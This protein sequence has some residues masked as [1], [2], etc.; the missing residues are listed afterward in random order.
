MSVQKVYRITL[1]KIMP[2]NT[3]VE[4]RQHF[5]FDANMSEV[6]SVFELFRNFRKTRQTSNETTLD[7]LINLS[8]ENNVEK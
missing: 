5:I 1:S 2:S 3:G 8:G 4:Y 7:S 6:K